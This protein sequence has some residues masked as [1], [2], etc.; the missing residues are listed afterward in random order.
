MQKKQII[1]II[2]E[3]NMGLK[4]LKN[5]VDD[6]FFFLIP[7]IKKFWHVSDNSEEKINLK[8]T[9]K[10]MFAKNYFS[11]PYS[12]NSPNEF[13]IFTQLSEFPYSP[14]CF[15]NYYFFNFT[16]NSYDP[17]QKWPKYFKIKSKLFC[18]RI[19]WNSSQ[20]IFTIK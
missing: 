10:K 2:S 1:I 16:Q 9:C 5:F 12:V 7:M 4:K 3:K 6:N 13:S 14:N 17:P 18:L 20:S 15:Q 11:F 8:K 19:F